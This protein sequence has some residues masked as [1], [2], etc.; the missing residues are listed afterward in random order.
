MSLVDQTLK[1]FQLLT[2]RYALFH[3]AF[4]SAFVM[5]LLV[6]LIFMP[7]LAKTLALA[8]VVALAFLTVLPTLC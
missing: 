4:L 7:F 6:I 2:R 3:A 1:E 5:E 8:V